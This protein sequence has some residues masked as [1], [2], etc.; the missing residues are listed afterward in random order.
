MIQA[1]KFAYIEVKFDLVII[2]LALETRRKRPINNL[3]TSARNSI[4]QRYFV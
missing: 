4:P 3:K 2:F 1:V